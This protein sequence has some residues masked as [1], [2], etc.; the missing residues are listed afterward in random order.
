M[1]NEELIKLRKDLNKYTEYL[2]SKIENPQLPL[3]PE[4]ITKMDLTNFLDKANKVVHDIE[5]M[6]EVK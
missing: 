2:L 5:R 3:F 1:T 6:I 4:P